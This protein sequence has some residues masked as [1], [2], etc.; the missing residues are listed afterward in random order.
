MQINMKGSKIV[1][2]NTFTT[3]SLNACHNLAAST[4]ENC[5]MQ[6]TAGP[7]AGI[8]SACPTENTN[9]M[10]VDSE[11]D[12]LFMPFSEDLDPIRENVRA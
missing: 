11:F 12:E 10:T 8:T 3:N 5:I 9:F 2:K 4:Y 7:H 6:N 1:V